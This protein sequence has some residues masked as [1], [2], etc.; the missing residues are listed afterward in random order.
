MSGLRQVAKKG[1]VGPKD[2]DDD[3]EAAPLINQGSP[4]NGS[5]S[6]LRAELNSVFFAKAIFRKVFDTL[7][8]T[9]EEYDITRARGLFTLLKDILFGVILG[10][11]TLSS[12]IYL[13]HHNVIHLQSAHN[14]RDTAFQL[15]NDPEIIAN[16]EESSNL[17]FLTVA[18][19]ESKRVV[20]DS[21]EEIIAEANTRIQSRIMEDAEKQ[22]EL[23]SIKAEYDRLYESPLLGLKKYC[24]ACVW[25]NGMSC[26][27]RMTYLQNTYNTRPIQAKVSSMTHPSCISD[28]GTE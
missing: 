27:Q 28:I 25:G 20:I 10:V 13:D 8:A 5:A 14:F 6:A 11:V 15:L 7:S 24:G 22:K 9:D 4:A 3:I 2:G 18:D 21:V 23:D 1:T 16:I 17:K 12:L 19:Y 26:D